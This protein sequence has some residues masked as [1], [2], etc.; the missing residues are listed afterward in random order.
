MQGGNLVQ[1][2][3]GTLSSHPGFGVPSITA[4]RILNGQQQ[5][6][7]GPE[8]PLT[9]DSF[10]YVA[11]CKVNSHHTGHGARVMSVGLLAQMHIWGAQ[12]PCPSCTCP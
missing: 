5:G 8:T 10:P 6:K 3:T 1:R 7:L 2:V 9:L 11:L 12:G 4:T